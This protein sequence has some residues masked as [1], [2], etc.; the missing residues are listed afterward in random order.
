MLQVMEVNWSLKYRIAT[1]FIG[2]WSFSFTISYQL[3]VLHF[4]ESPAANFSNLICAENSLSIRRLRLLFTLEYI[5][6]IK[7]FVFCLR[8]AT[9]MRFVFLFYQK[10]FAR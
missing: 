1:Q 5:D 4:V 9:Q 2:N 3:I 8:D 6:R 7:M 10:A